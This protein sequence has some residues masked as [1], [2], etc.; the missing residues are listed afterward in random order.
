M[1]ISSA[2]QPNDPLPAIL[3]ATKAVATRAFSP[4]NKN[5]INLVETGVH[6]RAELYPPLHSPRSWGVQHSSGYCGMILR[7][8]ESLSLPD[9]M[10]PLNSTLRLG[11]LDRLIAESNMLMLR[12]DAREHLLVQWISDGV[13]FAKAAYYLELET[14]QARKMW[15]ELSETLP[16]LLYIEASSEANTAYSALLHNQEA[17]EKVLLGV[18]ALVSTI[19]R[20]PPLL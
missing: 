12:L 2:E 20:G 6:C 3:E 8:A 1:K 16:R 17:A 5:L 10:G 18:L 7:N 15:I 13:G 19:S 14:D 4:H 9:E 11:L